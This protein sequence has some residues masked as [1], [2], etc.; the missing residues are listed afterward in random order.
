MSDVKAKQLLDAAG[1]M[2]STPEVQSIADELRKPEPTDQDVNGRRLT[3]DHAEAQVWAGMAGKLMSKKARQLYQRL[4]PELEAL[5]QGAGPGPGPGGDAR[6][7][8]EA[9]AKKPVF[10]NAAGWPVPAANVAGQPDNANMEEGFYRFALLVQQRAK[11]DGRVAAL[12]NISLADKSTLVENAISMVNRSLAAP[13]GRLE[14]LTADESN[15]VRSSAFTV[16]YQLGKDVGADAA[17]ARLR[18]RIHNHLMDQADKEPNSLF[19]R[20]MVRMLDRG[21]YKA[22]LSAAQK[23]DVEA[24]FAEKIPQKFDV[25]NIMSADGYLQWDHIAGQGEGFYRSFIANLP[26][27]SIHGAKFVKVREDWRGAEFELKFPQGRGENGRIKG[28]RITAREFNNDL[29]DGVGSGR[30]FSYGGHSNIGNNQER[31]LA[32][33]LERGLKAD[34]PQLCLLDLCAG[35][36]NLDDGLEKLGNLEILTTFGS[37]YFWKGKVQDERGEFDGVTRSE[38]MASLVALFTGLTSEEGYERI[39][40]RVN[41]AISSWSHERNPNVVFPTLKDYRE[42]RWAHLDGDG[43]ALADANDVLFHFGLKEAAKNAQ[44]EFVLDFQRPYDELAGEPLKNGVLDLNVSTHYNDR[45]SENDA[46]EHKFIA[47]GYFDGT[48]SA[49]LLRIQPERNHDGAPLFRIEANHGLAGT[50]REAMA[51]LTQYSSMMF[52]ADQNLV[53][54]LS[55][56]DRKLM[57]LT[58]ATFR[59]N[60]DGLGRNDDVRIW[61]QLLHAVRLPADLPFGALQSLV[62]AEHHDYAGSLEIVNNYKQ[63]LS[64]DQ[65]RALESRDVGRPGVGPP[66]A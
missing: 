33:A 12:A 44:A 3:V 36:D 14:G 6:P 29:F 61:K 27:Q 22:S 66:V 50:S 19:A 16:L 64:A 25:A 40:G 17:G 10:L 11:A 58:F 38:G 53:R 47:G 8:S 2:L 23:A 63:S 1:R 20:H 56:V 30:G 49:E 26:K 46:V 28:I 32:R 59:L 5:K 34:K 48:G 13:N 52:M 57:A 15:Q 45:T 18:T 37:S 51:A 21:D 24:L 7:L 31:S 54:G 35:L 65:L 42:V 41:D 60:F 39:R 62:D 55:E 43:D 4:T 9:N